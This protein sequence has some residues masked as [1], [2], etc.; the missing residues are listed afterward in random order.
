MEEEAARI[1]MENITENKF[2]KEL[3]NLKRTQPIIEFTFMDMRTEKKMKGIK[4]KMKKNAQLNDP[5]MK[6]VNSFKKTP[7]LVAIDI[8]DTPKKVISEVKPVT[9]N[10]V[11]S[12][13]KKNTTTPPVVMCPKEKA[14][15]TLCLKKV[16]EAIGNN[17][18][19]KAHKAVSFINALKSR[20]KR[21]RFLKK[22]GRKFD[23][24]KLLSEKKPKKEGVI[25]NKT[26]KKDAVP[27][28]KRIK[29]KVFK[30]KNPVPNDN[31]KLDKGGSNELK[32]I[33]K[34]L[35]NVEQP[36]NL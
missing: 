6:L 24:K 27:K 13:T 11:K 31:L 23:I 2:Y 22:L 18:F 29:K 32:S 34:E 33:F 14:A 8:E 10:S 26:M 36:P 4:E 17:S 9:T 28:T 5:R 16:N 30:K 35:E 7:K 1:Y 12:K 25:N 3:L 19:D 21:Q 20:G 15:Q